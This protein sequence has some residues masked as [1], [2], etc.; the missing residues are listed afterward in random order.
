MPRVPAFACVCSTALFGRLSP[1]MPPPSVGSLHARS[2]RPRRHFFKDVK[3]NAR[4][5]CK[6]CFESIRIRAKHLKCTQCRWARRCLLSHRLLRHRPLSLSPCSLFLVRGAV[7]RTHGITRLRAN[8]TQMSSTFWF[9]PFFPFPFRLVPTV[10]LPLLN[11]SL[12]LFDFLLLSSR[13]L[14]SFCA[15]SA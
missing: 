14:L 13:C 4:H 5:K 7:L 15:R 6:H 1:C 12:S 3:D 2:I 8:A 9:P 10:S 11:P